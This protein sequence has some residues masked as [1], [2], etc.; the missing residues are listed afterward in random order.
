VVNSSHLCCYYTTYKA[1]L[2]HMQIFSM[3]TIY[4]TLIASRVSPAG[5]KGGLLLCFSYFYTYKNQKARRAVCDL[6]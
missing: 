5:A 2:L 3:Y 6:R 4:H 1:I